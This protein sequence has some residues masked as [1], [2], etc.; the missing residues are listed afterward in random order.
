MGLDLRWPI[1]LLFSLVGALLVIYGA[2]TTSDPEVYRR[3]LDINV[4]LLWGLVV[5]VFGA[6]M[7]MA[8][9]RARRLLAALWCCALIALGRGLQVEH[10]LGWGI[11]CFVLAL[12]FLVVAF[13]GSRKPGQTEEASKPDKPEEQVAGPR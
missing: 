5:L 2:V 4:N 12:L 11:L 9:L 13:R 3:S 6:S 8:A 1:G 10:E 7:L